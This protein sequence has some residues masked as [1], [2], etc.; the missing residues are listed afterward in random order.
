MHLEHDGASRRQAIR[1]WEIDETDVRKQARLATGRITHHGDHGEIDVVTL[2]SVSL[3][4][5]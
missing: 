4:M 1:A 3:S 5:N 2:L